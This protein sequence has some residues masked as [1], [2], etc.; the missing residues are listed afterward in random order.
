M[1][2]QQI[3]SLVAA[4]GLLIALV[5]FLIWCGA[6]KWFGHLPG[7]IRIEQESTRV[8]IPLASMLAVSVG[9]SL[10]IYILRKIF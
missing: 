2:S 3:G 8:F 1:T 7:D 4:T 6:L 5:G 10:V 9:L